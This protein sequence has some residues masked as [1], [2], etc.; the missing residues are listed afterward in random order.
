LGSASPGT[1][2]VNSD[3][4]SSKVVMTMA[5]MAPVA[6]VI[7]LETHP[8]RRSS[9]RRTAALLAAK[10]RHPSYQGALPEPREHHGDAVV[11]DFRR[12]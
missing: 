6:N 12:R 3:P 9:R 2:E 7:S 10:R 4:S 5:T 8:A 1:I 11:I